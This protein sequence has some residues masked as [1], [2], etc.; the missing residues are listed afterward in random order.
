MAMKLSKPQQQ[1]LRAL[2]QGS[3]LKSHRYLDG[4]KIHQLH[5]LDGPAETIPRT[6]VDTLKRHRLIHSNQ[7]FPSA[8]YLLTE[9]GKKLAATLAESKTQP[10]SARKYFKAT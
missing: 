2:L 4:S 7:K 3:T 10:L 8:T 1:V 6:V 9:K 5:P